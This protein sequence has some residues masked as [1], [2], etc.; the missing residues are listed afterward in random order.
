MLKHIL[1]AGKPCRIRRKKLL[2]YIK[3]L[4]IMKKHSILSLVARWMVPAI[5]LG[6]FF[7]GCT[8]QEGGE[9]PDAVGIDYIPE[10]EGMT[11]PEGITDPEGE[12]VLDGD[13]PIVGSTAPTPG[14]NADDYKIALDADTLYVKNQKGH[15][16]VT[17]GL[18]NKIQDE[19]G[20]Q[21]RNSAIVPAN[22]IGGYARVSV[23]APG[24]DISP[25]EPQE[26]KIVSSGSSVGFDVIPREEGPVEISAIVELF[27]NDQF[28]GPPTRKTET[29]K[30]QVRVD[31]VK[32]FKAR[33]GELL[34]MAWDQF[35]R[36]WGAFLAL[37][38]GVLLFSFRKFLR[39]KTGYDGGE[40]E[41]E[42]E[43]E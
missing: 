23:T 33:I 14:P 1:E 32:N 22:E 13:V 38:F 12:P 20:D 39:K 17:I 25:E 31:N 18:A 3:R 4:N 21:V 7:T 34:S 40:S 16:L 27:D 29:I 30:V 42:S 28:Q 37:F 24:F 6:L 43:G 19:R 2:L 11:V 41:G 15:V 10:P 5:L 9:S 26:M 35:V 36:F 8:C